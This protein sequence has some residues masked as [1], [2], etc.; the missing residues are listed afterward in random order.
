LGRFGGPT[1]MELAHAHFA[2]MSSFTAAC[3]E[4]SDPTVDGNWAGDVAM[5]VTRD[6]LQHCVDDRS[7]V[8]DAWRR[9]AV[10][11]GAGGDK[12]YANASAKGLAVARWA[13]SAVDGLT[14]HHAQLGDELRRAELSIGRRAFLTTLA[15]FDWN[16]YALTTADLGPLV[17]RML[18]GVGTE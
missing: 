17:H 14:R 12:A 11:V 6:L 16:R 8:A 3:V 13:G 5:F 10:A 7:E 15:V 1:G 18:A 4:N 2:V 9:L